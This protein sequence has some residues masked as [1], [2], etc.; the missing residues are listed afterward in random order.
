MCPTVVG[1]LLNKN[2]PA[3]AGAFSCA[4]SLLRW[5]DRAEGRSRLHDGC[6]T[7]L[8]L[9][10]Q[11]GVNVKRDKPRLISKTFPLTKAEEAIAEAQKPA[12]FKVVLDSRHRD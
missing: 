9:L 8:R 6:R 1:D 12:A 4:G 7:K 5:K 3:Y 11:M 10:D 2:T